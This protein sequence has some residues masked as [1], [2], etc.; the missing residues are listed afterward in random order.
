MTQRLE[1]EGV[2]ARLAADLTKAGRNLQAESDELDIL[3]AAL[4]V[5]YD[6]L[7]VVRSQRTSSLVARA[8]AIMARVR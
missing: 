5:V 3:S 1:A 2:S 7:Q 6:D 8:V 4:G